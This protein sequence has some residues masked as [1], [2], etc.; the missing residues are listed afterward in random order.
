MTEIWGLAHGGGLDGSGADSG[1]RRTGRVRPDCRRGD[2]W[3]VAASGS[4]RDRLG[5]AGAL[6]CGDSK[7]AVENRRTGV[8]VM[9]CCCLFSV[10]G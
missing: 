1:G 8:G 5:V 7:T 2:G 4:G 9:L 6:R 3:G 10:F